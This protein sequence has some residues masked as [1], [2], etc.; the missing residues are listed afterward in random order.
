VVADVAACRVDLQIQHGVLGLPLRLS[1]SAV[2]LEGRPVERVR[3][4]PAA[5]QA[6]T[7]AHIISINWSL[8]DGARQCGGVWG[9]GAHLKLSRRLEKPNQRSLEPSPRRQS[10][11]LPWLRRCSASSER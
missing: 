2:Q 4:V 10:M 6:S 9:E 11:S 8:V 7:H 3:R 1:A 5:T